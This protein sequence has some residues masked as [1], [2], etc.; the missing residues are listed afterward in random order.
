[1]NGWRTLGKAQVPEFPP[2]L[3]ELPPLRGEQENSCFYGR[4]EA[5]DYIGLPFWSFQAL[6][7]MLDML[8]LIVTLLIT[9]TISTKK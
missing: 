4:P 1:M 6:E 9:F 2:A 8:Q 3:C 7:V 5:S